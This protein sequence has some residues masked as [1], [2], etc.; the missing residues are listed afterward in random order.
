[1]KMRK[2]VAV[3]CAILPCVLIPYARAGG[4]LQYVGSE[5]PL[6]DPSQSKADEKLIGTWEGKN[7]FVT[8]RLA[9]D[10]FPLAGIEEGRV[11]LPPGHMLAKVAKGDTELGEVAFFVTTIGNETFFHLYDPPQ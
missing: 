7:K 5:N 11:K 10:R 6:A 4:V 2:V 3:L 1:M 9:I 8:V